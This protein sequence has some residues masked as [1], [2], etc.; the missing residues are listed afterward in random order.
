MPLWKYRGCTALLFSLQNIPG[1][2]HHTFECLLDLPESFTKSPSV[3]QLNI[4]TWNKHCNFLASL[5]VHAWFQKFHLTKHTLMWYIYAHVLIDVPSSDWYVVS[6]L[7][8]HSCPNTFNSSGLYYDVVVCFFLFTIIV[9]L[10]G[11]FFCIC[12]HSCFLNI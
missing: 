7:I 10:M 2:P 9:H 1:S 5:Q 3:W 4:I 8:P 11:V 12:N 6:T